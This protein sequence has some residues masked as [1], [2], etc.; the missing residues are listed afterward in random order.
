MTLHLYLLS[1]QTPWF[2]PVLLL[3]VAHSMGFGKCPCIHP[4]S[5]TRSSLTAL[6]VLCRTCSSLPPLDL[7]MYLF[8]CGHPLPCTREKSVLQSLLSGDLDR[9]LIIALFGLSTFVHNRKIQPLTCNLNF[10][11]IRH[12][13]AAFFLLAVS[14]PS[15]AAPFPNSL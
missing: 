2:T 4:G 8:A 12:L 5:I 1:T 7:C 13:I 9:T 15:S 3:G 11:A 6:K 10:K 14:I